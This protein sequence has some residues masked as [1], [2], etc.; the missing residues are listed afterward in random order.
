MHNQAGDNNSVNRY[1]ILMFDVEI[2]VQ[3]ISENICPMCISRMGKVVLLWT[4]H[5]VKFTP[6]LLTKLFPSLLVL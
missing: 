2:F 4:S 3:S 6:S 5:S 1:L